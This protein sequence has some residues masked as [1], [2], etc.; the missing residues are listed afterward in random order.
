MPRLA[1]STCRRVSPGRSTS[2]PSRPVSTSPSRVCPLPADVPPHVRSRRS[3]PVRPSVPLS[4]LVPPCHADSSCRSISPAMPLPTGQSSPRPFSPRRASP[5]RF[6]KPPLAS[7]GPRPAQP[8][9]LANPCLAVSVL[10]IA[11]RPRQDQSRPRLRDKPSL[12]A[13]R[14][15]PPDFPGQPASSLSVP[16]RR[17]T[18]RAWSRLSDPTSLF[19]SRAPPSC[20]TSRVSPCS[21]QAIPPRLP[22]PPPRRS[23]PLRSDRPILARPRRVTPRRRAESP[24]AQP[25]HAAPTS[26]VMPIHATPV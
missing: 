6:D 26:L 14:P 3:A 5:L 24:H 17:A 16:T 22:M 19:V 21:C 25:R 9:R 12:A 13:R 2:S 10:A 1:I 7:P 15:F 20:P 8:S 4:V 23:A 18:I 11:D